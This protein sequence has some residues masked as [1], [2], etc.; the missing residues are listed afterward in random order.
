MGSILED[1]YIPKRESRIGKFQT[2]GFGAL[3]GGSAPA[4]SVNGSGISDNDE[5]SSLSQRQLRWEV[6]AISQCGI[7]DSNEDSYLISNDLLGAFAAHRSS[8]SM[9]G[10]DEGKGADADTNATASEE[11]GS[12]PDG[13]GNGGD[14]SEYDRHHHHG[15][16]AIFD[17]H[18]GNHA[19]RFATEKLP[20]YL[21]EEFDALPPRGTS[22]DSNSSAASPEERAQ[23]ALTSAITR[24]DDDFC[25]L[26]QADGREWDCGATALIVLVVGDVLVVANVGDSVGVLC[27]SSKLLS[28]APSRHGGGASSESASASDGAAHPE[29]VSSENGWATLELDKDVTTSKPSANGGDPAVAVADSSSS[30]EQAPVYFRVVSP[31]HSPARPDEKIRIEAAN[32]WITTETEIPIKVQLQRMDFYDR[33]VVDIL[34]RCFADRLK[35]HKDHRGPSHESKN[36]NAEPG[37]LLHISRVCGELAVSRALGDRDFKAAFNSTSDADDTKEGK[38]EVEGEGTASDSALWECPFLLPYPGK[39]CKQFDGDLVSGVPEIE[40]MR[41]GGKGV[42]EEFLLLACDGL[43]DVMDADDAVRVTRGLLFDRGWSAKKA[44]A[45]LAE[46]AIHLG[47]SDNVTVIVVRFYVEG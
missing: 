17:G 4:K 34:K 14:S 39:H 32:G 28:P 13:N 41:V 46:L 24:L 1:V 2:D 31:I 10:E 38:E 30:S 45:R 23:S 7:R 5:S 9:G 44:A 11:K 35:D 36:R 27:K 6:G 40:V 37:R 21:M 15:L 12:D 42:L 25:N 47:S 22:A 33:D 26:C 29:D 3:G 43:W 19:A 18:C 20:F 8:S 16:F